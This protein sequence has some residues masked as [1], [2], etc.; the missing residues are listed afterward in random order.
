MRTPT[1]D[2]DAGFATLRETDPDVLDRDELAGLTAQFA[3]VESWMSAYKVRIARRT[4]GLAAEGRDHGDLRASHADRERVIGTIKAAFVQGRLTEDELDAACDRLRSRGLL[5][6]DELTDAGRGLREGID[7]ATD[8]ME[9]R[10]VAALG[11]DAQRLFDLLDPW[12]DLIVAD[13]G[14][15][16]RVTWPT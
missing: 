16:V 2:V 15:P 12:C 6:G 1:V 3:A 14:Y 10:L 9:G 8:R 4:R 11:S 7:D 5:D 13:G